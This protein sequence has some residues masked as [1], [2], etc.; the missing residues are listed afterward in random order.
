M[1]DPLNPRACFDA[2]YQQAAMRLR[3]CADLRHSMALG[4]QLS[5]SPETCRLEMARHNAQTL[6]EDLHRRCISWQ[7]VVKTTDASRG[8][9]PSLN[10]D[11]S[12]L[13]VD[14]T[15]SRMG[16]AN[17]IDAVMREHPS[18]L[19]SGDG[20]ELT[21]VSL[22]QRHRYAERLLA[23]VRHP[24]VEVAEVMAG[25]RRRLGWAGAILFVPTRLFTG[26]VPVRLGSGELVNAECAALPPLESLLHLRGPS[27]GR[28]DWREMRVLW[29]DT[30]FGI[31]ETVRVFLNQLDWQLHS[32]PRFC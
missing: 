14:Q 19:L 11:W 29:F 28:E 1:A 18:R 25:I 16:G 30:E 3:D 7:E 8:H 2:L 31:S 12:E 5:R 22:E 13:P 10:V 23:G 27:S 6:Q 24:E 17:L 9:P 26:F 32:V 4:R 20:V 15:G 21:V